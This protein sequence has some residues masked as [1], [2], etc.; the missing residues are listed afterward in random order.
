MR[1]PHSNTFQ[2]TS[3]VGFSDVPGRWGEG[4]RGRRQ[5]QYE[6]DLFLAKGGE[7]S[8]F[9]RT[10]RIWAGLRDKDKT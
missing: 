5:Q 8:H 10:V 4:V 7:S 9:P 6:K 1:D 2:D 3:G